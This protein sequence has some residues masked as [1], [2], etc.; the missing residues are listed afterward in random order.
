MSNSNVRLWCEKITT[1]RWVVTKSLLDG[2][3]RRLERVD[4]LVGEERVGRREGH[5]GGRV[6][7]CARCEAYADE[8]GEVEG[9]AA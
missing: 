9:N 4:G 6:R 2:H 7:R 8:V 3:Q 5:E 1:I